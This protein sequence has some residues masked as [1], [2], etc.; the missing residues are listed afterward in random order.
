[1]E[2]IRGERVILRPMSPAEFPTFYRWATAS[3]AT[4]FWYEDGRIPTLEE[5][6]RDWQEYYFNGSQPE[7][8]RCFTILVSD[9]AIGSVNYNNI[10]REGNSVELDIIIP[11]EVNTNQGYGTDALRTLAGYLFQKMNIE[12]CFIEPFTRNIRAI[13]AY[14]K[15]GF[16]KTR[17]YFHEGT[18]CYHME[19]ENAGTA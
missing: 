1:M 13:K 2:I 11:E 7:K 8:G 16:R 6:A 12:M 9:R 15:A 17:T 10:N 5:F 14:E 4:P 19:M 18:E 3:E